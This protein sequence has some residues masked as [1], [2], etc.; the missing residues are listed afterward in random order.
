MVNFAQ[1]PPRLPKKGGFDPTAKFA[2]IDVPSF[3][4][5]SP[6][7]MMFKDTGESAARSMIFRFDR[8]EGFGS[9]RA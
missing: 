8:G 7:N 5:F 3:R 1:M 9:P 2:A 4:P 6:I